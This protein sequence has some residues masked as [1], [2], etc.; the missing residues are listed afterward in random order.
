MN[1]ELSPS[2]TFLLSS[3]GSSWMNELRTTTWV[4][5][6]ERRPAVCHRKWLYHSKKYTIQPR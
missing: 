1:A 5:A 3:N 2:P 6:G 4:L